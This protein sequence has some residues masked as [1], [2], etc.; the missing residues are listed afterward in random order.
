MTRALK[1]KPKG[2]PTHRHTQQPA[3]TPTD[4]SSQFPLP[5]QKDQWMKSQHNPQL[6]NTKKPPNPSQSSYTV[7]GTRGQRAPR[8]SPTKTRSVKSSGRTEEKDSACVAGKITNYYTDDW[9]QALGAEKHNIVP[10]SMHHYQVFGL[11]SHLQPQHS[12]K[13]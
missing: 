12:A 4:G 1:L 6:H 5:T 2:R 11:I 3:E 7:T 10:W 8:M 13:W 9:V